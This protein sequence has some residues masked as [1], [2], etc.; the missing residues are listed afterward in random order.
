VRDGPLA[1]RERALVMVSVSPSTSVSLVST[2][3]VTAVSS[4]VVARRPLR[5]AHH[6]PPRTVTVPLAVAV[7]P[8]PSL[9]V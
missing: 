1:A 4:F 8:L 7:P 6:S 9:I 3:T 2:G 5:L